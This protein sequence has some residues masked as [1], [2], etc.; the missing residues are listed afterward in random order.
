MSQ[1]LIQGSAILAQGPFTQDAD[2]INSS[3]AVYPK[4]VVDGWQ[5]VDATLPDGFRCA[6]YIWS[7]SALVAKPPVVIPPVVPEAVTMR[8]ARLALLGA[9]MLAS[10]N[11][12]IAGMTGPQGEAARIEWEFSSEVKRHQPL[13]LALGPTLGLTEAQ[14]DALFVKA[15]T[16]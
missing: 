9:G 12:A 4:H 14:L 2:T 15:A 10:V 11:S 8:Q 6:D 3:D 13:V 7:G 1:L 5:I 16:L